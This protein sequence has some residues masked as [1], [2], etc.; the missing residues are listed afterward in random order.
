MQATRELDVA[1]GNRDARTQRHRCELAA[2]ARGLLHR[3]DRS[4]RICEHDHAMTGCDVQV[5]EHVA[6]CERRDQ[7]LFRIPAVGITVEGA[8]S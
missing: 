2:T 1:A 8:I 3:A 7:E 6:L 5:A 4:I